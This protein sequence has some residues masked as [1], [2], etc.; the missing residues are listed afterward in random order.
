VDP[1]IHRRGAGSRAGREATK[2]HAERRFTLD[3]GTVQELGAHHRRT[4]E[5]AFTCDATIDTDGFVFSHEHDCSRPW[6][7]DFVTATFTRLRRLANVPGVRFHDLR[8][9]HAS[10]LID[11]GVPVSTVAQ[12]LDHAQTSTTHNIF[13]HALEARDAVAAGLH[14]CLRTHVQTHTSS[15]PRAYPG[16]P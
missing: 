3:A 4:V 10:Y 2:T 7:P 9:L 8:H 1:P 12:R 5:R 11:A 13:V 15:G 6:R 16:C 14:P